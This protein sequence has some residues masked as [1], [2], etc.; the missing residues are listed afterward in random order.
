MRSEAASAGFYVTGSNES[1]PRL[2][3][4]TVAELLEGKRVEYRG[5]STNTTYKRAPGCSLVGTSQ[6]SS[7]CGAG[8]VEI[9]AWLHLG[10]S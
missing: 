10:A 7:H 9:V 1:C 4:L 5:W 6:R 2:Q 3:L 8:I